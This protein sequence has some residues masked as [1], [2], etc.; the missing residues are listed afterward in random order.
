MGRTCDEKLEEVDDM[1]SDAYDAFQNDDDDR[2]EKD[3][4][5]Q[6]KWDEY[7]DDGCCDDCDMEDDE[8]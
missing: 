7:K 1:V 8:Y 2:R 3:D 5:W 4:A 6:D